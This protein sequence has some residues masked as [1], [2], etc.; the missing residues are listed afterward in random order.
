MTLDLK[1]P[2]MYV[3]VAMHHDP[4]ALKYVKTLLGHGGINAFPDAIMECVNCKA[5]V[6]ASSWPAMVGCPG[7]GSYCKTVSTESFSQWSSSHPD[8]MSC[9]FIENAAKR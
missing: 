1:K 8:G 5:T 7:C 4:D 3:V 9:R 2:P 6:V